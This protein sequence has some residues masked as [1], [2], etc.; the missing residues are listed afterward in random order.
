MV[1]LLSKMFIKNNTEYENSEVRQKYGILTSIVGIGL[2]ILLFLGKYIVGMLSGAVSIMADALNNLSDACS[3]FITLIGFHLS[4]KK[5][6]INH[7]FGHGRIEYIAGLGVSALILLMGVELFQSSVQKIFHPE[8]MEVTILTFSMLAASV[9]VK[10]Y[11]A[12]YNMSIG[13]KI[14]SAAM[15][16]TAT[17][18]LSDCISTSVVFLAMIIYKVFGINIDGWSGLVVSVLILIAGISS[19][20]ETI[21]PLLGVA[22]EKEFVEEIESTVLAHP[23]VSGIHDMMVHDYGPGRKIISL[24]A[25]VPG[26][27]DIFKIHDEIDLIEQELNQKFECEA[28]IHMDPI[29]SYDERVMYLKNEVYKIVKEYDNAL[30]MHDFRVVTGE[31][32]T[33]LIFDVV[34]P[35]DYIINDDSIETELKARILQKWDNHYAVIKVERSYVS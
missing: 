16:A 10:C 30:T 13:K 2:N 27:I 11:M 12:L 32:H 6:D 19:V 23:I 21:S 1:T 5:P 14:N 34:V 7:P 35:A 28:V 29:A 18:S 8:T 4:G 9:L 15:K 3:S 33:N 22:P 17:D 26:N 24:H 20:K 31:T 25:E